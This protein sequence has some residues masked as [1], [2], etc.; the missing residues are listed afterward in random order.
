MISLLLT[1]KNDGHIA[2]TKCLFNFECKW[3]KLAGL[4][5]F[6]MCKISF[7]WQV[8][9]FTVKSWSEPFEE[10]ENYFLW[11]KAVPEELQAK[12]LGKYSIH[13][14]FQFICLSQFVSSLYTKMISACLKQGLW[15]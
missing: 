3:Q 9:H 13:K 15:F 6:H 1:Y 12:A 4:L 11:G 2:Q 8:L 14:N 5:Y 7:V 10:G